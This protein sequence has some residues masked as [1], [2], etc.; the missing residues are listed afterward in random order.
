MSKECSLAQISNQNGLQSLSLGIFQRH[1]FEWRDKDT[2]E[3]NA[4][5]FS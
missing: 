4:L 5:Y 1:L 3:L 2:S